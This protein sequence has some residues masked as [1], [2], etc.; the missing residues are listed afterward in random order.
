[1]EKQENQTPDIHRSASDASSLA[2]E[3]RSVLS[4]FLIQLNATRE[5]NYLSSAQPTLQIEAERKREIEEAAL[6]KIF[7]EQY[8]KRQ[9][10][11]R[12][13]WKTIFGGVMVIV[14][15]FLLENSALGIRRASD[16]QIVDDNYSA[17]TLSVQEL[18]DVSLAGSSNHINK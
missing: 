3:I 11:N 18:T 5:L 16:K 14:F 6:S 7:R 12:V 9:T 13:L 1:V 4:E 15:A 10:E 2:D 8:E 17:S